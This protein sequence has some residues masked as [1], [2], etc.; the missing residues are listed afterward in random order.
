MIGLEDESHI[1]WEM[2]A[3]LRRNRGTKTGG[4]ILCLPKLNN[5]PFAL[6]WKCAGTMRDLPRF[7]GSLRVFAGITGEIF[8][9]LFTELKKLTLV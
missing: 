7:T 6:A 8:I 9:V 5:V 3:Y 2:V 4:A 1:V